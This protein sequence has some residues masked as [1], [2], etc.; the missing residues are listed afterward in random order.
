MSINIPIAFQA[1]AL[2]LPLAAHILNVCSAA[3]YRTRLASFLKSDRYKWCYLVLVIFLGL[4]LTT[5]QAS[6]SAAIAIKIPVNFGVYNPLNQ[7]PLDTIGM[8]EVNS[9]SSVSTYSITLST[10]NSG[11]YMLRGMRN[12]NVMLDYN[13]YIDP[14]RTTVWGNGAN[15]TSFVTGSNSCA[16][17][18]SVEYTIFARIPPFQKNCPAGYYHDSLIVTLN[19]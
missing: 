17:N 15:N 18:C 2:L 4:Q 16:N 7:N 1:L 5:S 9:S 12:D 3:R 14:T 10:G 6:S 13:V 19:Y 11:N 8:I